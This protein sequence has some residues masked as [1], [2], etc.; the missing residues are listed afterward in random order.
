M[1]YKITKFILT[2]LLPVQIVFSQNE[3]LIAGKLS[4][5]E[6]IPQGV[7]IINLV[8][9][10]ETISDEKGVFRIFVKEDD[11][12][13]FSSNNFEYQRKIIEATDIKKGEIAIDLIAK[14]EQLDE[15]IIKNYPKINAVSLGILSQ[16]AKE[17]TPAERRLK[18]AGEFKP[19]AII[20]FIAGFGMP[21][22][23]LF[24]LI[25]GRTKNLKKDLQIERKQLMIEKL[26]SLFLEEYYTKKLKITKDKI[27]AFHYF[28][29]EDKLFPTILKT[30]NKTK[31]SFKM[32]ELAVAFNKLNQNESE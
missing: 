14:I 24:N 30:N 25:S 16:P 21:L 23:P 3:K 28:C 2:I 22:D 9:E 29:I 19:T 26:E 20:G 15:V 13:V 7:R 8:S 27:K 10:K 32:S 6:K 17:Y 5:K 31:I 18:T 1:N 11:L 12:L 4:A